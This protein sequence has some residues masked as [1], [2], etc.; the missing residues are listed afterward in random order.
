[1]LLFHG[2]QSPE[3]SRYE[4]AL[5]ERVAAL[6]GAESVRV[7]RLQHPP[8]LGEAVDACRSRGLTRV[9]VVP[10]FLTPGGHA[11]EDVPRL[12]DDARHRF[13]DVEIAVAEILG[14]HADI[15]RL[16][17]ELARKVS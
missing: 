14:Q 9:V 8:S 11:G 7:A 10:M 4:Q 1:M 5:S 17:A 13:P 2:S 3:A 12:V 15:A 16:A 6:A